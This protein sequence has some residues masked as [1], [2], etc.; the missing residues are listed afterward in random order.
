MGTVC[1]KEQ[2]IDST[3][4]PELSHFQLQKIIGKGVFGRVRIVQHK[5]TKKQ[6]ALKYINKSIC[7]KQRSISQIISERHILERIEH[8]LISNL[9]YAFQDDET[10]FMALDLMKGGDLRFH[11]NQQLYFPE[12]QVRHYI[13]ATAIA[14]HYLHKKRIV[15]RDIK[16]ENILLDDKGYAHVTDFNIAIQLN[17]KQ[18]M[19]WSMAGTMAYMAP[20]MVSRKGYTTAVDWWSLGIMAYELLFGMRP[21]RSLSKEALVHSIIHTPVVFPDNVYELVTEDCIDVI[22]GLLDKSPFHRLGCSN[23]GLDKFKSHPWFNG[24]NWDRL[25][26]KQWKPP[27]IP[28]RG[29]CFCYTLSQMD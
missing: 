19:M 20:E 2:D 8:P 16:P 13:A 15:H 18:P 1:C 26:N 6:Y 22:T 10:L 11:L 12:E 21:F 17:P 7:I 25:E 27:V 3:Q 5:R 24:I 9:R 14:L 23:D 28:V 29:F 4:E